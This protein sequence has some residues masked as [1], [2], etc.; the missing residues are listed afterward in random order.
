MIDAKGFK[1]YRPD[2]IREVYKESKI[3]FSD[4]NE[5][6]EKHYLICDDQVLGYSLTDKRWCAFSLGFV[7]DIDYS[8]MAFDGLLLPSEQKEIILSL[9]QV[10][11]NET[12][13]F[14]DLIQDKGK[15]MI[16]LLHGE[17]GVGKTLTAGKLVFVRYRSKLIQGLESVADYVKRPLFPLRSGDLGIE[18][19][20]LEKNLNEGFQLAA[21]WNAIILLDEADVF[22]EAR[23]RNELLRNSLVTGIYLYAPETVS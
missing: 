15:G 8:A 20:A 16:F 4:A 14:K 1:E 23:R 17:P 18:A 10:H 11:T 6:I 5:E 12:L 21:N 7:E 22:L 19:Q 2:H 3:G 9:V 13:K